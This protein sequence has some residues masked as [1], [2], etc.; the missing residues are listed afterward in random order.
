VTLGSLF[1]GIG[2]IDLACERADKLAALP[3]QIRNAIPRP[4]PESYITGQ[5]F[6]DQIIADID[7]VLNEF[8]GESSKS[9][10]D[11]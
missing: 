5:S 1:A 4:P 10:E 3:R 2:G 7:R 8:V 6:A 9:N 11:A